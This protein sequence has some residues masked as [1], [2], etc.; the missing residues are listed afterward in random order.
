M[1]PGEG[2]IPLSHQLPDRPYRKDIDGLRAVAVLAVVA[3][4]FSSNLLPGGYLGV[5]IFFVI[6]G[7]VITG[8]LGAQPTRMMPF[9]SAFYARRIRRI[10]PALLVCVG[11]AAPLTMLVNPFAA[12][13]LRTGLF[14]L[15][16]L[17]NLHLYRAAADYFASSAKLDTFTHTWSLGVEEQFY[18]VYPVLALLLL[19]LSRDS[20]KKTFFFGIGLLSALSLA[21]FTM[22]QPERPVAVFYLPWFRLW[23]LGLGCLLARMDRGRGGR[24]AA[25]AIGVAV[26]VL[27]I[28]LAA[29][30]TAII[31]TTI[32]AV[33]ATG[34]LL[35]WGDC[36]IWTYPLLTSP[37]M[38]FTGRISYSLYLWHW[39]VLVLSRWTIGI[40]WWSAPLQFA[41]ML[42]IAWLSFCFVETPW[43]KPS[44]NAAP[45]R[46]IV[47]GLAGSGAVAGML[48]ILAN[49][50][51]GWLFLGA[52]PSE[53]DLGAQSIV[54]PYRAR[55]SSAW[56]GKFCVLQNEQEAG[57]AIDPGRC[58]MA[59][60]G[61]KPGTNR[62]LL[63]IGNSYAP[64]FV[65][66]FEP[67]VSHGY[68]VTLVAALGASPTPSVANH[69][70]W[71]QANA[72]LWH[73]VYPAIAQTL[74]PGDV[75]LLA[76]DL[77]AILADPQ[78]PAVARDQALL[79]RDL[80]A[81][82]R[83][84]KQRGVRLTMLD[85][86]PLLREASCPPQM[87]Y[88]Q[89]YAPFGPACALKSRSYHLARRG[90]VH[91]ML[92]A[93]Q[94]RGDLVAIDL[95]DLFCPGE[96]CGFSVPGVTLV[97]RDE[98]THP[99]VQMM[100]Q[101]GRAIERSFAAAGLLDPSAAGTV[102]R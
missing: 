88:H 68:A 84:L 55:G 23:E 11:I 24:M 31:A 64:A 41:A 59:R 57:R 29:P 36:K 65:R 39:P 20:W 54:K 42:G 71:P 78:T 75:V 16:G 69:S 82:S 1:P 25:P 49:P 44:A 4:H 5:D 6:S 62:R 30:E 93:L 60:L 100:P 43:R 35:H 102:P 51:D 33:V 66:A 12:N 99:S 7:F 45:M 101:V 90:P 22:F 21:A 72:A 53:P 79:R 50:L 89:W 9:L 34:A 48:L 63:V 37:A 98:F 3:N 46:T 17:A 77:A 38:R 76:S 56:E 47:A 52:R 13:S 8:S 27:A 32:G 96:T 2:K 67:L 73:R 19:A 14:A 83:E 92:A 87:A 80:I 91:S 95:F 18:F 74:R 28:C 61:A 85:S 58:T 81:M 15:F 86:L 40:H 70:P 97:Y 94:A 26:A 10:L